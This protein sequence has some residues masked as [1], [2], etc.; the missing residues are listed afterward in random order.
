MKTHTHMDTRTK[1]K[2]KQKQKQKTCS[3]GRATSYRAYT[4]I[5]IYTKNDTQKKKPARAGEL[6]HTEH[7][8]IQR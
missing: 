3:S 4:H 5:K 2:Q 1:T 7:T 6:R 8:H